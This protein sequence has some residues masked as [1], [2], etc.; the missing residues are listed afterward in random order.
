[1][2][3][4]V[5]S[6]LGGDTLRRGGVRIGWLGDAPATSAPATTPPPVPAAGPAPA[7]PAA[8]APAAAPA[9]APTS[10][11]AAGDKTKGDAAAGPLAALER[12]PTLAKVGIGVGVAAV[13]VGIGAA[14]AAAK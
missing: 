5:R 9:S 8:T 7:T 4:L 12:L 14:I 11:P 10:P 6:N 1:M 3:Q 2:N 13:V